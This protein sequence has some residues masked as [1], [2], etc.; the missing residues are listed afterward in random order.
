MKTKRTRYPLFGLLLLGLLA[1]GPLAADGNVYD[2]EIV[3]FERP[4]GGGGEFW[5]ADPGMPDR[6]AALGR[7][8]DR[9]V[10]GKSLGPMAYSLKKKGM[11]IHDHLA[12]RQKPGG[13]NSDTWYWMGDGRLSG[14]IRV[15]RGRYLHLDTDLVLIDSNTG[16]PYRIKLHRRM[17]SDELHYVDHPRLGILIRARPQRAASPAGDAAGT[18]SG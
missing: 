8:E 15:T 5:P 9:A 4:G 12:W 1:A 13:R 10:A 3:V 16:Q 7:L 17:R 11:I 6:G 14:L 2:I 18:S